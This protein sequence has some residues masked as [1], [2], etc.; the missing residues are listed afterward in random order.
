MPYMCSRQEVGTELIATFHYMEDDI[1]DIF[2]EEDNALQLLISVSTM[3]GSL[4]YE[5]ATFYMALA[6]YWNILLTFTSLF[7]LSM[8]LTSLVMLFYHL[9]S[10]RVKDRFC[11]VPWIFQHILLEILLLVILMILLMDASKT[12]RV[13]LEMNDGTAGNYA[14]AVVVFI[15]A[16][17]YVFLCILVASMH[18]VEQVELMNKQITMAKHILRLNQ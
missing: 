15:A 16:A 12:A 3:V 2:V 11:I 5:K 14:T 8:M 6:P 7:T 4:G 13:E 18:V 17:V 10:L 1:N 9:L